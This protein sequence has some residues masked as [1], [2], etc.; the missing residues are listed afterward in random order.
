KSGDKNQ[1]SQGGS[2]YWVVKTDKDG[3][4]VW[5][6]TFG[7]GEQ[8]EAYSVGRS[9]GD[10]LFVAGTSASGKSGDKSQ[11]SQGKKDYWLI[12]LDE[13]GSKVWDKTFGGNK[14][15]ELRASTFTDE[16]NYIL[17]G[18]SDSGNSGDKT[19]SSQGNTDYWI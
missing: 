4:L 13:K 11:V 2:D 7:G 17:A 10:Y 8:D 12:Q 18:T 6:K 14:D 3:D 1:A 9:Y 16:G 19:Q 5:E 15:D